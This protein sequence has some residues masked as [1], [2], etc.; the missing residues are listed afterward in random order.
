MIL[1]QNN[2]VSFLKAY[3]LGILYNQ[4]LQPTGET[5]PVSNLFAGDQV[6]DAQCYQLETLIQSYLQYTSQDLSFL[7]GK[8]AAPLF[9]RI[10]YALRNSHPRKISVLERAL[11]DTFQGGLAVCIHD[12]TKN[13]RQLTRL[14]R[15]VQKEIHRMM[16]F[17][18]FTSFDDQTLVASPP[19]FHDTAD[20]ILK[21]FRSRYPE[22]TLVFILENRALALQN[23]EIVPVNPSPFRKALSNEDLYAGIWDEYYQSQYIESRRNIPLAQKAIPQKYWDW[24]SE[25]KF[26]KKEKGK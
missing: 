19:L 5:I 7:S 2:A 3:L 15:E 10:N 18:R 12:I 11:S 8:E 26:L 1:Y 14:A 21:K 9:R 25:G 20:L 13:C 16:G 6:I 22:F 4:V 24:M 17:I 23:N